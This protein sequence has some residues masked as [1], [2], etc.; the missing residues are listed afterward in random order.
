MNK[1]EERKSDIK[2]MKLLAKA[3]RFNHDKT[4]KL[5]VMVDPDYEIEQYRQRIAKLS[6]PNRFGMY[7]PLSKEKT[8]LK[9]Q[10]D[11]EEPTEQQL[12]STYAPDPNHKRRDIFD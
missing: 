7:R 2:R 9:T 11:I 3:I 12:D 5:N 4:G 10:V 6:L 8:P 1:D